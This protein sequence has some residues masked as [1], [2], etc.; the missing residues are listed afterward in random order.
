MKKTCLK[1]ILLFA[2]VALMAA[3]A[4]T[5]CTHTAGGA[6][7][8]DPGGAGASDTGGAEALQEARDIGEGERVFR[9][10]IDDGEG[11]VS[12]WNVSTDE[13]AV[14]AALNG[15]GLIDGADDGFVNEV[16]GV[17]ADYEADGVY[18]AFYVDGDYALAGV[19][20]TDI[21]PG[22]VYAFVRTK[23]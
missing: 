20:S 7:A 16:D 5:G 13:T 1:F 9:F 4:L 11:N 17:V 2:S 6:G 8:S 22:R 18:W 12:A 14:G 3:G 19:Y 10:E 15:V 23:A 21:E